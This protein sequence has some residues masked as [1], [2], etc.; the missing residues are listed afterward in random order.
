MLLRDKMS[1]Y[2]TDGEKLAE[3]HWIYIEKLLIVH[4][5]DEKTIEKIKFHYIQAGRH[6]Y[7]HGFINARDECTNII[8][9]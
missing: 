7:K 3:Q 2:K 5:E 4:G 6:F 8:G 1:D 9:K